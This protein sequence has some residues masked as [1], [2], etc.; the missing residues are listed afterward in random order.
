MEAHH[1]SGSLKSVFMTDAEIN[2]LYKAAKHGEADKL[3]SATEAYENGLAN[4]EAAHGGNGRVA[5]RPRQMK[6]VYQAAK[7]A[8]LNL[9]PN[10]EE[11]LQTAL[12]TL[13]DAYDN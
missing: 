3:P 13:K 11:R 6:E 10:G 8:D 5:I 7:R 9:L 4:L 2:E 12:E 1:A